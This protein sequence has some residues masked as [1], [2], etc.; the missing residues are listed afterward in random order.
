LILV[1]VLSGCKWK[2]WEKDEEEQLKV[3][4]FTAE[5]P[6]TVSPA[7][8][9]TLTIFVYAN[10]IV[11]ADKKAEILAETG[12]KLSEVK[13]NENQFVKMGDV[14][15]EIDVSEQLLEYEKMAIAKDKAAKELTAWKTIEASAEEEDLKIRTGL[16]EIEISMDKLQLQID[17]SIIRAPFDGTI[18]DIKTVKGEYFPAGSKA[19][20][21]YDLRKVYVD[22]QILETEINRLKPGQKAIIEIPGRKDALY[23][24]YIESVSPYIDQSSRTCRVRVKIENDGMLKE[25]MFAKVKI[26]VEQY[27]DRILIVKDALLV[28]DGKKL[29]FAA[30]NGKAK[31]QYVKT[32]LEN[33]HLLEI[34]EGVEPGQQIIIEGQFSLSHD[35]NINIDKE[36]TYEQFKNEF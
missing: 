31:W 17:K 29:I 28:R 13:V 34:T 26:G 2:F 18:T 12:G 5:M 32:G 6:V 21:V 19:A 27:T 4:S 30:E 23:R 24:G 1:I 10:G 22:V 3:E 16:R 9:D 33:N 15:A 14:I 7:Q 11:Y 35:A 20:V 25:G 36:L 8:I